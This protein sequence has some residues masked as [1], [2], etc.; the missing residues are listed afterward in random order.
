[1]AV[2][3]RRHP[4]LPDPDAVAALITEIAAAEVMPRFCRLA[5]HEIREKKPGDL[6]TIADEAV[7][8]RLTH[9]LRSLL[10]GSLVL[11]EE[12]AAADPAVL[13]RLLGHEAVWIVD[14]IDGTGNFAAGRPVFAVMVALVRSGRVLQAWIH[15]PVAGRTA[16]AA[17]GAGAWL[18]GA[19]LHV[20]RPHAD[21]AAMSGTILAG[22]FGQRELGRR[23]QE[24]RD[25]VRAVRSLRCAGHEY[26]RLIRGEMD[27]ALFSRL[28]PWD[29]APGVLLHAEAGGY[30]AYLE[31]GAFDPGRI[32]ASGILL[33]PDRASW[34]ALYRALLGA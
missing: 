12:A 10:P 25:R 20:A 24:R 19:R 2:E 32:D 22:T 26:L 30:S 13:D 17:A 3:I 8:E 31:G 15:D 28:M 16:S 6:V 1:L 18:D 4:L 9:A 11:G 23:L 34:E 33:A 7:E 29:H 21:P 14:P 5:R 27:F